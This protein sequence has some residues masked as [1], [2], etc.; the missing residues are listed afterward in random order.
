M[1]SWMSAQ[2]WRPPPAA[3]ARLPQRP[4]GHAQG[5]AARHDGQPHEVARDARAN[6]AQLVEGF[7]RLGDTVFEPVSVGVAL[8]QPWFLP[9]SRVN[10]L[11]RK[12]LAALMTGRE[13]DRPRPMRAPAVE[14]PVPYPEH[15]LTYLANVDNHKARDFY[16]RHVVHAAAR[17]ASEA[18]L[19]FYRTRPHER[20]KRS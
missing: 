3:V 1:P 11:R 18:P 14:P 8:P 2:I 20:T 16:A 17:Q 12:A 6:E 15:L 4:D 10:A 5:F 9:A 19:Q 7:S 13:A